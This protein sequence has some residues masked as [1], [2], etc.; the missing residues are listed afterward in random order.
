MQYDERQGCVAR[1]AGGDPEHR[2]RDQRQRP[3]MTWSTIAAFRGDRP[4]EAAAATVGY[5]SLERTE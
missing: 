5:C 4:T 2:G 3:E 1:S